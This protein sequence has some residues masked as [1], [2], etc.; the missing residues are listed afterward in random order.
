MNFNGFLS[1]KQE[2]NSHH[3]KQG[4]DVGTMQKFTDS[5]IHHKN[6]LSSL[7]KTERNKY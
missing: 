4:A 2:K 5:I 3:E 6:D 7:A 1:E